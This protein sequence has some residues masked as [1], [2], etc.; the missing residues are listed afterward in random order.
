MI[1]GSRG[2]QLYIS[3]ESPG[4]VVLNGFNHQPSITTNIQDLDTDASTSIRTKV[5]YTLL[6]IWIFFI[7]H[8]KPAWFSTPYIRSCYIFLVWYDDLPCLNLYGFILFLHAIKSPTMFKII[9]RSPFH[10]SMRS[11]LKIYKSSMRSALTTYKSDMQSAL[12]TY[13][14]SMRSALT[15]YKSSMRSALTT[16]KSNM[17]S[18]LTTY[19]RSMRSALTT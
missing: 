18:A 19:K 12:K 2:I 13:K 4:A 10:I 5:I 6:C 3:F 16:Y 9:F 17:W 11:A 1:N 14:R 15:T 8:K 7:V